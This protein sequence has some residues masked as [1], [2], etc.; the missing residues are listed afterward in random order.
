MCRGG[1]QLGQ[2]GQ[3]VVRGAVGVRSKMEA[4]GRRRRRCPGLI[5]T[6]ANTLLPA[7]SGLLRPHAA[8]KCHGRLPCRHQETQ[9]KVKLSNIKCYKV[10]LSAEK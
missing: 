4:V 6:M 1:G 7:S 2:M 10:S 5:R 8:P 9:I 3:F